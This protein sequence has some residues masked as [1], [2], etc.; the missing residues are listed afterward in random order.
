MEL[1]K[2]QQLTENLKPIVDYEIS[3]GNKI[4]RI[5]CPAGTLCPLAVVFEKSL[6]I[7]AFI[8]KYGMPDKVEIWS[9]T[10]R[11]YPLEKGYVCEKTRQA[12]SGPL[13]MS[14]CNPPKN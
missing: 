7:A 9:N 2:L 10:D 8:K 4:L 14:S 6:D 3:R 5:D 11:H 12:L 13:S 1:D